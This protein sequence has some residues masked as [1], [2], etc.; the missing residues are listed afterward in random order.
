MLSSS[1]KQYVYG[2]EKALAPIETVKRALERLTRSHLPILKEI[3]SLQEHDRIGIPVFTC[4]LNPQ[5]G[6]GLRFK[7]TFGKGVNTEQA[8]ASALMELVERFSGFS[9]LTDKERFLKT[10]YLELKGEKT[11]PREMLA[12]FPSVYRLPEVAKTLQDTCLFWTQAFDLTTSKNCLLPLRW[13]TYLYGTTGW[14]AGNSLEEAILQALCEIWERHCV[15]IIIEEQRI[16]PTIEVDSVKSEIARDILD[17]LFQ[18]G[19]EIFIK[20]F[21]L[22]MGIPTVAVIGYDSSPP[23]S[24]LRIY[25]AAGTHLNPELALIRALN[26]FVQHR[27]QVIYREKVEK[28]AGGP[29]YCFPLFK[30]KEAANF[31]FQGPKTDLSNLKGFSHPDFKVEIEYLLS[32]LASQGFKAFMVETTHKT[33]GIPSVIVTVPGARLNR[34]STKV[35]PYLFLARQLAE[36]GL[37]QEATAFIEKAF[38]D[39][40]SLRRLPQVV[41]QAAM[42]YKKAGN[43]ERAVSYYEQALSLSPSLARAPKFITDLTESIQ[44]LEKQKEQS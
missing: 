12:P 10:N 24:V 3:V 17:K 29:T 20:D 4:R 27:A 40:P 25:A 42:C 21:S 22:N 2:Q 37:Y 36:M 30:N 26:E 1:Y 11:T 7:E 14:A 6:V 39:Q 23:V 9:F 35:H 31:L 8:K 28:K 13:F 15:S 33:L 44:Q 19:I 34:P 41:C 16:I 32:L 43:F 18:A 5:L 38:R